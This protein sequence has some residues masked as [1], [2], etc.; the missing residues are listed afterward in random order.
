MRLMLK[1]DDPPLIDDIVLNVD[2]IPTGIDVIYHFLCKA[3]SRI[4][5]NNQCSIWGSIQNLS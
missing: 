4:S 1:L 3:V 2:N 5:G